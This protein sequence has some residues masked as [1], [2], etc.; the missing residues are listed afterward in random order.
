[1]KIKDMY[2]NTNTFYH[3]VSTE[4]KEVTPTSK[5]KEVSIKEPS[6]NN[7]L[8]KRDDFSYILQQELNKYKK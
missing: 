8:Y 6:I 4:K 5:G 7:V 1:M 2:I 3:G